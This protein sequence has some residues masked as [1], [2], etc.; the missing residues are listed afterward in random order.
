MKV[1]SVAEKSMRFYNRSLCLIFLFRKGE[2]SSDFALAD[3][4]WGAKRP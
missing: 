4:K 1:I 3:I 2:T